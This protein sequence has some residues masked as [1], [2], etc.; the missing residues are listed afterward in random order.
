M[1]FIRVGT[2]VVVMSSTGLLDDD[3]DCGLEVGVATIT[4]ASVVLCSTVANV[5]LSVVVAGFIIG[6]GVAVGIVTA[7]FGGN[8]VDVVGD[9]VTTG[10][11]VGGTVVGAA[12][13][14]FCTF[15]TGAWVVLL[16][17]SL[18]SGIGDD[19]FVFDDITR[20]VCSLPYIRT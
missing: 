12:V 6:F 10:V 15:I 1:D 2:A 14:G 8:V 18:S 20:S 3:V 19:G 17:G 13:V 16:D 5:G 4:G 7:V 9:N 11:A